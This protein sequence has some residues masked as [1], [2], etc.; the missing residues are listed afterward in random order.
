MGQILQKPGYGLVENGLMMF[1]AKKFNF[2]WPEHQSVKEAD[3]IALA[4]EKR[5]LMPK[6]EKPWSYSDGIKPLDT[7]IVPIAWHEA[8]RLFLQRYK[9]ITSRS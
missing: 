7:I 5:D 2:G 9:F 3:M 6:C 1:V 4:T 8:E